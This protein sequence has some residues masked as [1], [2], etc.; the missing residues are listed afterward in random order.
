MDKMEK[1]IEYLMKEYLQTDDRLK[2]NSIIPILAYEFNY[3]MDCLST[4][5]IRNNQ[6]DNEICY[7]V[8][9]N[10][11]KFNFQIAKDYDRALSAIEKAIENADKSNN[12]IIGELY[13]LKSR[14]LT[15]LGKYESALN[16]I[17]KA[18][19]LGYCSKEEALMDLNEIKLGLN[20]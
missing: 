8:F 17:N 2:R 9:L 20:I 13:Y 7:K 12:K 4:D 6:N 19:E 1:N 16:F 5:L 15:K 10:W 11:S 14:C 3:Y 18:F